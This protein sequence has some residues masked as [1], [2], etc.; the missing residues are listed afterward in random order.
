MSE[1]W[2]AEAF[3][4]TEFS[5]GPLFALLGS[6]VESSVSDFLHR[7]LFRI[8]GRK[9]RYLLLK[10][11]PEELGPVIRSGKL[12]GFNV[13]VP[14]KREV[15]PFLDEIDPGAAAIGSVNTVVRRGGRLIGYNTDLDGVEE[16]FR[17]LGFRPSGKSV[18]VLGTGGAALTVAYFLAREGA[19]VAVASRTREHAEAFSARFAAAGYRVRPLRTEEVRD[20]Y[21]AVVNATP[22]GMFPAEEANPLDLTDFHTEAVFD[23]VYNPQTTQFLRRANGRCE[24]GLRMLV[25]QGVRAQEHFFGKKFDAD[26]LPEVLLKLSASLCMKRLSD[27]AGKPAIALCGFMGSGKSSVARILADR[28]GVPLVETDALVERQAGKSIAAIFRDEG[29]TAFR[30][31]ETGVIRELVKEPC[32]ISLGGGSVLRPENVARV[33]EIAHLVFLD[34]PLGVIRERVRDASSRPLFSGDPAALAEL[35][36]KRREICRAC[37]DRTVSGTDSAEIADTIC[38]EV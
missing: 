6:K 24:N 33:R 17:Y 37:A 27:R 25:R 14:Y 13:T 16:T 36:E 8:A 38:K 31:L 4:K 19:D 18:L 26:P 21:A 30:D 2:T 1:V 5:D 32:V 22:V 34:V 9:A 29:E 10:L 12:N 35:Y 3:L 23:L 7:N 15:M 11:A 28:A 20:E